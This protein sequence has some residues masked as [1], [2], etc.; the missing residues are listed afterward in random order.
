[1]K[2]KAKYIIILLCL[3]TIPLYFCGM[4]G[5]KEDAIRLWDVIRYGMGAEKGDTLIEITVW[6]LMQMDPV[7]IVKTLLIGTAGIILVGASLIALLNGKKTYLL[8]I[9]V[10]IL[11]NGC[12]ARALQMLSL[13]WRNQ[14]EYNGQRTGIPLRMEFVVVWMVL[15]LL[16]ILFAVWGMCA[17]EQSK[18]DSEKSVKQIK[19][20]Q[21]NPSPQMRP[22][23]TVC[24]RVPTAG[25]KFCPRCGTELPK[26]GE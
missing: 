26:S 17:K 6:N 2:T 21:K 11:S 15:H 10:S 1:M 24:G 20:I 3:F 8:S 23:C 25:E 4:I 22:A 13:G 5:W 18:M 19:K 7:R 9:L 12:V 14:M 16:I